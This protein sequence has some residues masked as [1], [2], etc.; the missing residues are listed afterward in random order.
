MEFQVQK[1]F[2][3]KPDKKVPTHGPGTSAYYRGKPCKVLSIANGKAKIFVDGRILIVN[4]TS[5]DD[6]MYGKMSEGFRVVNEKTHKSLFTGSQ[7]E[8]DNYVKENDLEEDENIKVIKLD[9]AIVNVPRNGQTFQKI[10]DKH[11]R[12]SLDPLFYGPAVLCRKWEMLD[13]SD[14]NAW[15]NENDRFRKNYVTRLKIVDGKATIEFISKKTSNNI[16]AIFYYSPESGEQWFVPADGKLNEAITLPKD[17]K[18]GWE[19]EELDLSAKEENFIKKYIKSKKIYQLPDYD[20]ENGREVKQFKTLANLLSKAQ[21]LEE[22]KISS[23]EKY[24]AYKL[25]KGTVVVYYSGSEFIGKCF[26]LPSASINESEAQEKYQ[27]FFKQKLSDYGVSSPAE[28][29]TEDKSKFFAEIKKEWPD[30]KINEGIAVVNPKDLTLPTDM[31]VKSAK[32]WFGKAT[33]AIELADKYFG[34]N[35]KLMCIAEKKQKSAFDRTENFLYDRLESIKRRGGTKL[36]IKKHYIVYK[37]PKGTIMLYYDGGHTGWPAFYF[38]ETKKINESDAF[39]IGSTAILNGE[40]CKVVSIANGECK[41]VCN[42]T[43][44][45]CNMSELKPVVPMNESADNESAYNAYIHFEDTLKLAKY[46]LPADIF[47]LFAKEYFIASNGY[48]LDKIVEETLKVVDGSP[49]E[50]LVK[51]AKTYNNG[52]YNDRINKFIYN[53]NNL[54]SLQTGAPFNQRYFDKCVNL[55]MA[56]GTNSSKAL[57]EIT[58]DL[59]MFLPGKNQLEF[60]DLSPDCIEA[61]KFVVSKQSNWNVVKQTP[62]RIVLQYK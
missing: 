15:L 52:N 26:Y 49:I 4:Y 23:R 39:G 34:K 62:S 55:L 22:F 18:Y 60:F 44:K 32:E 40:Q 8:C 20:E 11:S 61:L 45:K 29:S 10:I 5:L 3:T 58:A 12:L 33:E 30:A 53:T 38:E 24:I 28:L 27:A 56:F 14:I 17:F 59:M 43:V 6:Q 35:A 1:V 42:G 46:N 16:T 48:I 25:P 57:E 9:E 21:V 47:K 31:K 36:E 2:Q 50:E 7:D 51:M 41:V 54:R 13:K 19:P 37:M